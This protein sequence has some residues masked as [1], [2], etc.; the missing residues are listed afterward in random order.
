M[1]TRISRLLLPLIII[2]LHA[3]KDTWDYSPPVIHVFQPQAGYSLN[4]PDTLLI[5]GEVQDDRIIRSVTVA[6]LNQDKIPVA[7]PRYFY[8]ESSYFKLN[9]SLIIA[10]KTLKS[11]SY[12]LAV[13]A[14][15][16]YQVK[17]SY[18]TLSVN[19][20]PY[21]L[22]G[23]LAVTAPLSFISAI[24]IMDIAFKTDTTIIFPKTFRASG[25]NNLWDQFYF[26][27][28][29][30][31]VIHTFS[32]DSWEL[33]R[34]YAAAPPRPEFT[35]LWIDGQTIF[36]TLNGDAGILNRYGDLILRSPPM[37]SKSMQNI[38]ADDKFI[39]AEHVSLDGAETEL[40]VFYRVTGMLRVQLLIK[41]DIA[42]LIPYKGKVLLLANAPGQGIISDYDPGSMKLTELLRLNQVKIISAIKIDDQFFIILTDTKVLLY[43]NVNNKVSDYMNS[44]YLFGRFDSVNKYLYLVNGQ[45]L[46]VIYLQTSALLHQEVFDNKI[47][48]FHII[49]NK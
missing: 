46:D 31:G 10:D 43:D 49:Y 29:I 6:L 24:N 20:T 22:L 4:V 21:T 18:V 2:F 12:N 7:A 8:P 9:T 37:S 13:T 11:G 3:C 19:E 32:T 28:E 16:G 1:L 14:S 41:Q 15:D 26:V 34:Q 27:S 47:V 35:G 30:P 25:I 40:T 48:D 17:N 42:C 36:S 39:Y 45:V 23:Y 38:A 44:A 33:L 5:K